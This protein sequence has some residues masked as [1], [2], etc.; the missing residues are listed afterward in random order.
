MIHPDVERIIKL[1][2]QR[3]KEFAQ[4]EVRASEVIMKSRVDHFMAV[5]EAQRLEIEQLK[6]QIAGLSDKLD[7]LMNSWNDFRRFLFVNGGVVSSGS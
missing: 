1:G 2:D 3:A 4:A 6:G 5:N 7:E